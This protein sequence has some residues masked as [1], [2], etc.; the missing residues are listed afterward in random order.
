MNFGRNAYLLIGPIALLG[1]LLGNFFRLQTNT[2]LAPN[3]LRRKRIIAGVGIAFGL[4]G[5][6]VTGIAISF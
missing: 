6:V 4:A 3:V 2:E 5:I 1:L